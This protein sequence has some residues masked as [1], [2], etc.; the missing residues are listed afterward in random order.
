MSNK[1]ARCFI[2][3]AAFVISVSSA[4]AQ[5]AMPT[6]L[7]D[8]SWRAETIGERETLPNIASTLKFGADYNVT[9]DTGCNRYFASVALTDK[10]LKFGPIG[11]TRM[12]CEA[13]VN[14][15]EVQ[16]LQ[17]LDAARGYRIVDGHLILNDENGQPVLR[18]APLD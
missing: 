9:G 4:L 15:Q 8:T 7:A 2:F 5:S 11:A 13:S 1:P 3:L 16:F 10:S 17:A 12:A 18:L 14:E 6:S